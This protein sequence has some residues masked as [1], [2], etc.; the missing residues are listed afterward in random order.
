[1]NLFWREATGGMSPGRQVPFTHEEELE[2][3]LFSNP[4]LLGDFI[5]LS[6][7]V[8]GGNKSGIPDIIGIDPS[9]NVCVV[10]VKNVPVDASILPQVLQYAIWAETNPDSVK[11]TWL[12][13]KSQPEDL[14]PTFKDYSVRI[15]IVAPA[16]DASVAQHMLKIN[17][18][19]DLLEINRYRV[20]DQE[21]VLINEIRAATQIKNKPVQGLSSYDRAFYDR[22][23]K[24]ASV[25]GFFELVDAA[26]QLVADQGWPIEFK[27]NQNY[28]VW[29]TGFFQV[30][31]IQ[32]LGG[33]SFSFFFKLPLEEVQK[34]CPANLVMSKYPEGW[35]QAEFILEPGTTRVSDFLPLM[36]ASVEKVIGPAAKA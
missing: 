35:K 23:Y 36:K 6:R 15:I 26:C 5:P 14:N 2:K 28:V 12:E 24:P 13:C 33:K 19:V 34:V 8:R 30:F 16:I 22:T 11:N 29:K 3:Y 9:G 17:F 4:S 25:A 10:E 7:Q 31:G 18:Q 21:L 1:M 20:G 27:L 32:G